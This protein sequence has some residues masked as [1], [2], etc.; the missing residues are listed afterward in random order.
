MLRVAFNRYKEGL[1]QKQVESYLKNLHNV[2]L[3][4]NSFDIRSCAMKA[5]SILKANHSRKVIFGGKKS[6]FDLIK[7]TITKEEWKENRKMYYAVGEGIK[8]G[9]RRFRISEDLKTITFQPN[10]DL[11]IEL[12]ISGKYSNFQEI[13]KKLYYVQKLKLKPITY[14]LSKEYIC[15]SF[16]EKILSTLSTQHL[17]KDRIFAIDINPNYIGYSVVDWKSSSEFSLIKS[18]TIS[19]KKLNDKDFQF[20]R[21]HNVSS[22]DKR[23]KSLHNKI[24]HEIFEISKFLTRECRHYGCEYFSMDDLSIESSDKRLGKRF[25]KLCNNKWLRNKFC[26]NITKRCGILGIKVKTV[27]ASYS[28]FSG[29]ILFRDLQ[30]PDME[31]ASVEI[32]RRCYEFIHQYIHKDAQ[33]RKNIVTPDVNDFV[34]RYRKSLEESEVE[35]EYSNLVSL[36]EFLKKSK[37]RYRLSVEQLKLQFSR[38]FSYNSSVL[39]NFNTFQLNT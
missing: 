35:G 28:S 39:K 24:S 18:G 30:R 9:N 4:Q 8:F 36:Y 5:N 3:V 16:D 10:K 31:L 13:I 11:H 33:K 37:R 23:R 15:I 14:S 25:N 21:L 19:L 29:N 12:R 2:E 32:G 22:A 34:D 1:N 17:V 38:C 27:I 7:G 20:D 26:N 6:F